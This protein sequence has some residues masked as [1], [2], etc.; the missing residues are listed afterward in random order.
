MLQVYA[1]QSPIDR[2]IRRQCG[3]H[4]CDLC[5]RRPHAERFD[6]ID[7]L[8][9]RC[10]ILPQCLPTHPAERQVRPIG[11]RFGLDAIRLKRRVQIRPQR[12]QSIQADVGGE[13]NPDHARTSTAEAADPVQLQLEAARS[14][15]RSK[16]FRDGGNAMLFHFAQKSQGQVTRLA[17]DPA[18]S[19]L[20]EGRICRQC[21]AGGPARRQRRLIEHGLNEQPHTLR[22][23][24]LS[25]GRCSTGLSIGPLF[26]KAPQRSTATHAVG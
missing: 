9:D 21:S 13:A 23:S 18:D 1:R 11:A 6:A 5:N 24:L 26:H 19:T 10:Q 3:M 25:H 14:F 2:T 7:L 22:L 12:S 8:P 4:Q 17:A 15:E 16:R 20:G